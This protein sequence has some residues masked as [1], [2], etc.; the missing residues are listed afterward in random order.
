MMST[1]ELPTVLIPP[2]LTLLAP[3]RPLLESHPPG[4]L[5]VPVT[6][7]LEASSVSQ[8]PPP[9]R[10]LTWSKGLDYPGSM[11]QAH[12]HQVKKPRYHSLQNSPG[13][14]CQMSQGVYGAPP[15]GPQRT[16]PNR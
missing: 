13:R 1:L 2:V 12:M 8:R 7:W 16:E 11:R 14:N 15:I 3:T 4:L 9:P 10:L 5:R 6:T